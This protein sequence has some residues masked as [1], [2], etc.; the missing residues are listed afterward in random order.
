MRQALNQALQRLSHGFDTKLVGE[1]EMQ[2]AT[3]LGDS[4]ARMPHY[5]NPRKQR[6]SDAPSVT[7]L[8]F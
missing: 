1:R 7:G 8:Y 6:K 2:H 3:L 5:P 4:V